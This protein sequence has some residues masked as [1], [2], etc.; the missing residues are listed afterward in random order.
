MYFCNQILFDVIYVISCYK[1]IGMVGVVLYR[2]GYNLWGGVRVRGR[3]VWG[4]MES[5]DM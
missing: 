5:D 3:H 2:C 1:V 4:G